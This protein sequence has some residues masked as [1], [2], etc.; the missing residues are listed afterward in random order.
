MVLG[1]NLGFRFA[2]PQ[3]IKFVAFSDRN[4]W[5]ARVWAKAPF[6]FPG[7]TAD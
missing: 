2:A 5:D 6:L 4:V 3:A 1:R 7:P